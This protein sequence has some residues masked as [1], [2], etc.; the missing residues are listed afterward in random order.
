MMCGSVRQSFFSDSTGG[1]SGFL[2]DVRRVE[3]I[4]S[5]DDDDLLFW[6]FPLP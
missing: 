3:K 2:R 4:N 6:Y 1:F 5:W